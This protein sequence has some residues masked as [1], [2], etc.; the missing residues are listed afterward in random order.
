MSWRARRN[1]KRSRLG[2]KHVS[3]SKGTGGASWRVRKGSKKLVA[4]ASLLYGVKIKL[5]CTLRDFGVLR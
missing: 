3:R 2:N 1:A 5:T 4:A